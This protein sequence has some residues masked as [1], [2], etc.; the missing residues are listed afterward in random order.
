MLAGPRWTALVC[1]AAAAAAATATSAYDVVAQSAAWS[2]PGAWAAAAA[3]C[4]ATDTAAATAK[5]QPCNGAERCCWQRNATPVTAAHREGRGA[6]AAPLLSS[7]GRRAGG[8]GRYGSSSSSSSSSSSRP[9]ESAHGGPRLVWGPGSV[10]I[11]A[12]SNGG[13]AAASQ[14]EVPLAHNTSTHR[15]P[16]LASFLVM[17]FLCT[18]IILIITCSAEEE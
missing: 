17:S 10:T 18:L 8:R 11:A 14:Y 9:L 2:L 16:W 4:V 5:R 12:G 1:L 3:V 7:H 15:H 13:G 6:L